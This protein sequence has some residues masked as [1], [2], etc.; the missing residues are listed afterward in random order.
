[1]A[2][3]PLATRK[4][5]EDAVNGASRAFPAWAATPVKTRQELLS[6]LGDLVGVH[7]PQFAELLVREGGKLRP[8]A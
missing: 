6:K 1:V 7:L 5:L 4:Q 2:A 3:V 8:V